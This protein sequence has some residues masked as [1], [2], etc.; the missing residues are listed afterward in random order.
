MTRDLN[1]LRIIKK[2]LEQKR[3]TSKELIESGYKRKDLKE[4]RNGNLM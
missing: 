2:N 4:D 3:K 1:S